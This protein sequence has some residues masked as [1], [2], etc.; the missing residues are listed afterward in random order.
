ML[1]RVLT[2]DTISTEYLYKVLWN[3]GVE[4]IEHPDDIVLYEDGT[5]TDKE[6]IITEEK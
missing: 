4:Y 2:P 3:N 6:I 5:S 1:D